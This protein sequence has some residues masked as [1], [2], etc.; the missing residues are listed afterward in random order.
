MT[1]REWL[2]FAYEATGK[3]LFQAMH[4]NPGYRGIMAPTTLTMRYLHEDVPMSLVPIASLGGMLGVAT[5]TM[6]AIIEMAGA[7]NGADYWQCGR[8][9]ER[10]GI[11]GMTV[12]E[13]RLL[14][15]GE[16]KQ[17]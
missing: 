10:L 13:L 16:E 11:A 4:A 12:K 17:P 15:I 14:A 9:V 1:A 7:L 2:Y 8:T 3:N 6:R 5:P